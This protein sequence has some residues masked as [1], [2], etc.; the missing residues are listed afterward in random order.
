MMRRLSVSDRLQVSAAVHA[1][2]CESPKKVVYEDQQREPN[3]PLVDEL[4]SFAKSVQYSHQHC[5]FAVPEDEF[6]HGPVD[7]VDDARQA[8]KKQAHVQ[9]HFVGCRLDAYPR[10]KK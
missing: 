10:R 7:E 5:V 2:D 3:H 1:R 8:V 4:Y 6:K 9:E